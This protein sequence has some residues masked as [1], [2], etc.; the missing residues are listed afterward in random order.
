MSPA[1]LRLTSLSLEHGEGSPDFPP[2]KSNRA[3]SGLCLLVKRSGARNLVGDRVRC[4]SWR[5]P[6]SRPSLVLI[7]RTANGY[8]VQHFRH[9]Q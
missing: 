2:S 8:D 9:D 1:S 7:S 4:R 5:W 3:R 6:S